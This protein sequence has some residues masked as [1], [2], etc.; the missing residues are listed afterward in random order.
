MAPLVDD[1]DIFILYAA[2]FMLCGPIM[3]F[4][5]VYKKLKIP[6]MDH[7]TMFFQKLFNV[8]PTDYKN[9]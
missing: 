3:Y 7:V 6:G 2:G 8:A 1:P 4:I 5:F 9:N